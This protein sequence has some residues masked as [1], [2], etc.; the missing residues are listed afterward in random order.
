MNQI[1]SHL[2][3]AQ[4]SHRKKSSPG[5]NMANNHYHPSLQQLFTS[6]SG[7]IACFTTRLLLE[8]DS[9]LVIE[10]DLTIPKYKYL[11]ERMLG[12]VYLVISL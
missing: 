7:I 2:S 6:S 8:V 5:T 4:R 1:F 12:V 3:I 9:V 11:H 10:K